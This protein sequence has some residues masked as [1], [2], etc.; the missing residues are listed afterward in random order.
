MSAIP[1]DQRD[2]WIWYD[3]QLVPWKDAKL[4]VLTH[5]LHYGSERVRGRARLW[6]RDLQVDASIRS[7]CKRSAEI[8]DFEIPYTV[9]EIDAAK[10]LVLAAE[11][12]DGRLSAPGR[13]ARLGDDGRLGPAATR[14]TSPSPPGNGRAISTRPRR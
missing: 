11:R 3:G 1:F 13:L 10:R 14:S 6:R 4:H 8:L 9:A 12:P 2:G 7:G 5:G